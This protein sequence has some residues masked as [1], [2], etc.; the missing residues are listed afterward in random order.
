MR[1]ERGE[2]FAQFYRRVEAAAEFQMRQV[3]AAEGETPMTTDY[4]RGYADGKASA[5]AEADALNGAD[6]T[7][8][9]F[10][11]GPKHGE[12]IETGGT[13]TY[14][15][16]VIPPLPP[17][18]DLYG[19]PTSYS[20]PRDELTIREGRYER[21]DIRPATSLANKRTVYIYVGER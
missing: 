15:V 14:G 6:R 13:L 19:F 18:L 9:E 11:G 2:S 4:R 21:R 20:Y 7:M 10:I 5:K 3:R 8:Y 16:P 1:R 17:A 12:R